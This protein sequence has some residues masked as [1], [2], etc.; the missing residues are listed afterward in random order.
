MKRILQINAM[1]TRKY[2]IAAYFALC[3]CNSFSSEIW[4]DIDNISSHPVTI[5]YKDVDGLQERTIEDSTYIRMSIQTP[6]ELPWLSI[7]LKRKDNNQLKQFVIPQYN[8]FQLSVY[9]EQKSVIP[10]K[11]KRSKRVKIVT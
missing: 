8:Y 5:Y 7:F 3:A 4:L 11:K 6:L 9:P 1:K 2:I 10:K